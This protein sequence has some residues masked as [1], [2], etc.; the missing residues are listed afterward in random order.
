MDRKLFFSY[1][2]NMQQ[3]NQEMTGFQ[4]SMRKNS[5]QKPK[6]LYE[7]NGGGHVNQGDFDARDRMQEPARR[8]DQEGLNALL[9]RPKGKDGK[10]LKNKDGTPVLSDVEDLASE[11]HAEWL[12]NDGTGHH[13]IGK[14]EAHDILRGHSSWRSLSDS[15]RDTAVGEFMTI[16]NGIHDDHMATQAASE[17]AAG[18]DWYADRGMTHGDPHN[19][20]REAVLRTGAPGSYTGTKGDVN[21]RQIYR[22]SRAGRVL[23]SLMDPTHPINNDPAHADERESLIRALTD[24]GYFPHKQTNVTYGKVSGGDKIEFLGAPANDPTRTG[25]ETASANVQDLRRYAKFADKRMYNRVY[26]GSTPPGFMK[27]TDE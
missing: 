18:R 14:E 17:E 23:T 4:N 10:P 9:V 22:T 8:A 19:P 25:P 3:N 1:I 2:Q 26:G 24:M 6:S 21:Y 13:G 12:A 16:L 11:A 5:W 15:A 7:M 20:L 27:P